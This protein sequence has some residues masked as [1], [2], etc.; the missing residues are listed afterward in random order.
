MWQEYVNFVTEK[1]SGF[2]LGIYFFLMAGQFIAHKILKIRQSFWESLNNWVSNLVSVIFLAY[3][4][5]YLKVPN[6]NFRYF[7]L[8]HFF[9][10]YKILTLVVVLLVQDFAFYWAHRLCHAHPVLW[11]F[12]ETH[13]SSEELNFST[14]S[15]LPWLAPLVHNLTLWPFMTFFLLLGVPIEVL[16]F[17]GK[18]GILYPFTSHCGYMIKN[19]YVSKILVTPHD[20]A[21]HHERSESGQ[22]SNYG[23]I[24]TIFDH[25]YGTYNSGDCT[26]IYGCDGLSYKTSNFVKVQFYPFITLKKSVEKIPGTKNKLKFLILGKV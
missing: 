7:D 10:E 17:T 21:L 20:H 9:N 2:T 5:S 12:H 24:F 6:I 26:Q 8:S 19:K 23:N 25:F 16:V 4:I 1:I 15:R 18:I 22:R 11:A 3:F 14:A 13:H